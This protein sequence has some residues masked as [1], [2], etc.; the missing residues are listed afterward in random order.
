LPIWSIL[1]F[2]AL[3]TAGMSLIHTTDGVVMVQAY[4]WAFIRPVKKLYYNLTMTTISIIVALL[5]G[6]AEA[7]GI[8]ADK[9]GLEGRFGAFIEQVSQNFALPGYLIVGVFVVGWMTSVLIY[10]IQGLDEVEEGL[11]RGCNC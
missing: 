5:I 7:L 4:G 3:F 9:L 1:I 2:P 10:R 6:G 8:L 11:L